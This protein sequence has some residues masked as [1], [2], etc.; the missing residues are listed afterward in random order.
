M[1]AVAKGE[2]LVRRA[3]QKPL[4]ALFAVASDPTRWIELLRNLAATRRW[5]EF[6]RERGMLLLPDSKTGR[7]PVILS[8]AAIAVLEG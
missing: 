5:E 1:A 6:D 8:G 4:P 2:T 7:K 3:R